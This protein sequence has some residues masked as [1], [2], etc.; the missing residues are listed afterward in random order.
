M[1]PEGDMETEAREITHFDADRN[2]IKVLLAE[3]DA[4]DALLVKRILAKP[5]E[6]VKFA[7][8]LVGS[9]SAAIDCLNSKRY[10][11]VLLDM[12]LPDS[13]GIETVQKVCE[14]T[15]VP[16]VV[17]TETDYEE[18]GISA[19][20]S[21]ASDYLCKDIPLNALL[22]RA[23]IYALERKKVTDA[24][25]QSESKFRT[26]VGHLPKKIFIKDKNSVYLFSN[27]NYAQDLKIT[28]E[29]I[30]GKTDYDFYPGEL[31]DKYRTDDKRIIE[32]GKTE[33][34]EEKY[35]ESGEEKWVHTIKTPYKDAKG[36]IIGV[37]EIFRDIT[38]KKRIEEAIKN[39]E[40]KFRTLLDAIEHGVT[41][42]DKDYNIIYQNTILKDTFGDGIGKKCYQVYEGKDKICE[43]CPVQLAWKDGKSHTSLREVVLPSGEIT[44]WENVASPMKDAGGKIVACIEVA[45]NITDRKKTEDEVKALNQ[46]LE[47]IL[48]ATKT[49][50][51]IIDSESNIRFV[52]PEW[53]KEYGDP[54]GKKCYEYYMD[55]SEVC[56]G[57]GILKAL[58]TKTITVT[59]EVLVKENNRPIQVT[60]I[61]FQNEN[62]E[63][64]VAGVYVDISESKKREKLILDTNRQLQEASQELLN[65]KL[66][67]ERKNKKLENIHK[68]LERRVE[69]RTEEL[70][71]ANEYLKEEISR[72]KQIE[73]KLQASEENLRKVIVTSPDGIVIID[74]EGI[75]R[76]VNPAAESLFGRKAEKIVGE[77]FGLPLMRGEVTEIDIVNHGGGPGIAE[78]RVVETEWNGQNAYLALLQDVTERKLAEVKLKEANEKLKE[79]NQLKDEFV[80]TASHELRTPLSTIQSAIRLILD[81]IPG[82]IVEKQRNVLDRAMVNVKRLG[83]IVNSML[84][85]SKIESGR[86]ELQK[87]IINICD[88]IEST[89]SDYQSLAQD[90]GI[91][92]DCEVPDEGVNICL[93][94]DRIE[95]VLTNLLSNSL[96]F[97][98]EGGRVKVI[99]V[100]RDGEILVSVQDSGVGIAK[101]DIPRLFNKFT[102]FGRKAGPGEKGTGLG[103]AIVKKLVDMHD[104][105]IEVE[106]KPNKGTTFTITLPSTTKAPAE[107]L[108]AETDELIENTLANN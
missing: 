46:Q 92:L 80:S 13:S 51:N 21:G 53:K 10:D 72:R 11:V 106:S 65:A 90:K 58:E 56:H 59:E 98:P 95:E 6:H 26:L 63:W 48:G 82:S 60:A 86:L 19:I 17:L 33:D 28:P 64:L 8:E 36:N 87:A 29:E 61:P 103:L 9:V 97:T 68:D 67:L 41:I 94:P 27:R 5:S 35:I 20:R 57:C 42:Q 3:D 88:L 81:E 77:L 31:A 43:G 104:G 83:K 99:C 71:K 96:K 15:D 107:D 30:I 14:A 40:N 69:E 18:I 37:L 85:I 49:G 73:E 7:V 70:S 34:I 62:G 79:Y 101:E 25:A 93:D 75:V 105:R 55:R 12:D 16:V 1:F 66:D 54:T 76:F 47:F 74:G 45:K 50:L 4:V 2:L 78:M 38:E 100:E 102:Q 108:S 52:D 24:L 39:E 23:I 22:A 84:S 89:V 32:T 91:H 44:F